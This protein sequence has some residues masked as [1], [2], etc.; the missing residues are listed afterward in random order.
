MCNFTCIS[1]SLV[2]WKFYKQ[3][4]Q[5]TN[6]S[7]IVSI[8]MPKPQEKFVQPIQT[9]NMSED[10]IYHCTSNN[11]FLWPKSL[12]IV[13]KMSYLKSKAKKILKLD[14]FNNTHINKFKNFLTEDLPNILNLIPVLL[15]YSDSIIFIV[16]NSI[17][18]FR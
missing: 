4:R 12:S 18:S 9:F 6:N 1:I 16:K 17:L 5:E 2:D 7:H 10:W 11:Q 15:W 3:P 8:Q 13:K 14:N